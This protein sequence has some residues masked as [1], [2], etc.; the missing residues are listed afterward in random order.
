MLLRKS[1]LNLTST[2]LC[3]TTCSTLLGIMLTFT[4]HVASGNP[5]LYSIGR[6]TESNVTN[7]YI[8]FRVIGCVLHID[9]Q[10]NDCKQLLL[11]HKLICDSRQ[12]PKPDIFRAL[13]ERNDVLNTCVPL[14]MPHYQLIS[15]F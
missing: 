2:R 7:R 6:P 5:A 14:R 11:H 12:Y 1:D 4:T 3:F 9:K 10:T 8:F 15:A 13:M